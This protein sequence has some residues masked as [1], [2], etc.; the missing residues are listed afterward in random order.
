MVSAAGDQVNPIWRGLY[1]S[2]YVPEAVSKYACGG[3]FGAS[4]GVFSANIAVDQ[5]PHQG[6]AEVDACGVYLSGFGLE[7]L[8]ELGSRDQFHVPRGQR[9]HG[10]VGYGI[11]EQQVYQV[12]GR[13]LDAV[14]ALFRVR[15]RAEGSDRE[16][17]SLLA[18]REH[19]QQGAVPEPEEPYRDRTR[20]RA[21][22]IIG[23][24]DVPWDWR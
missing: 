6:S 5:G 23:D 11:V 21:F 22:R 14:P 7:A 18:G 9:V 1:H 3:F 15:G 10:Y 16:V 20:V 19:G 2:F 17:Y 13:E 24:E 12:G 4:F 8:D